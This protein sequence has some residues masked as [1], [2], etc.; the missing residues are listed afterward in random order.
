M[1]SP[2]A[3][4]RSAK[5]RVNIEKHWHIQLFLWIKPLFFKTEALYFIEI[6]ASFK[7]YNIICRNY[8]YWFVSRILSFIKCQ[9]SLYWYHIEL[10]S[11]R[12]E[13]P[14]ETD[15][16]GDFTDRSLTGTLF[17]IW[18]D[19]CRPLLILQVQ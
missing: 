5:F 15:I 13:V 17:S 2:F 18:S 9:C 8:N 19:E 11:L 14:L 3:I 4:L 6:L 10:C 16:K 12:S 7:R 1:G